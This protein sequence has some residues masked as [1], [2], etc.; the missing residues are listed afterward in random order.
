[1]YIVNCDKL[2]FFKVLD[3]LDS[4]INYLIELNK[5]EFDGKPFSLFGRGFESVYND[6]G[7]IDFVERSYYIDSV[8]LCTKGYPNE[9]FT[10]FIRRIDNNGNLIELD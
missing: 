3:S 2:K 6:D 5:N 9:Y 10:F 8:L 4:V 1:M 7:S